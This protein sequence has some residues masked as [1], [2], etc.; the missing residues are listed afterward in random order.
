MQLAQNN[1]S[2]LANNYMGLKNW[3]LEKRTLNAL[4]KE[5]RDSLNSILLQGKLEHE[6]SGKMRNLMK[7]YR[8]EFNTWYKDDAN[9]DIRDNYSF[10]S[11]LNEY[12]PEQYNDI[13]NQ[14][15]NLKVESII[16]YY[17]SLFNRPQ[18]NADTYK[19]I[20]T[21]KE[22]G[23]VN[24]RSRYHRPIHE[25]IWIQQ[26]KAVNDAVK[27]LNNNII[28]LFIKATSHENKKM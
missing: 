15:Y 7:P 27:S 12:K 22:G 18:F 4:N 28:R 17:N 26:N 24:S 13:Q 3:I 9:K 14:L 23:K 11:W 20:L 10:E 21:Q 1:A 2:R 16:P 25:E 6:L 8:N 19:S 5:K